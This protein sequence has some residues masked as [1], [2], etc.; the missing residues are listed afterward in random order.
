ML[1]LRNADDANDHLDIINL[2][3]AK[4]DIQ[5]NLRLET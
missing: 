1:G 4:E 5:Y 2:Q 3:K